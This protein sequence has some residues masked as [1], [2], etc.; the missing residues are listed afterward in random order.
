MSMSATWTLPDKRTQYQIPDENVPD[1]ILINKILGSMRPA[2]QAKARKE[3]PRRSASASSLLSLGSNPRPASAAGLAPRGRDVGV[4]CYPAPSPS[5]YARQALT[6]SWRTGQK[7]GR[8]RVALSMAYGLLA[9]DLN[10]KS[11]PYVVV[12][13]AG[14]RRKSRVI[15]KTLAPQW[16]ETLEFHGVLD[17]FLESGVQLQVYD[18]DE[19][20]SDDVLGELTLQLD[21]ELR[22]TMEPTSID[23]VER[24]SPEGYLVFTVTWLP[25]D[26]AQLAFGS[27]AAVAAAAAEAQPEPPPPPAPQPPPVPPPPAA[28]RTAAHP[29]TPSTAPTP[30]K[31]SG[32]LILEALTT[33]APRARTRRTV[34]P[35]AAG[36]KE[37]ERVMVPVLLPHKFDYVQLTYERF[38]QAA[39]LSQAAEERNARLQGRAAW[40]PGPMVHTAPRLVRPPSASVFERAAFRH[41]GNVM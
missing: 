3:Q 4:P 39:A 30:S 10:G 8:L 20:G 11:D 6:K 33:K 1:E 18:Y 35:T 15:K 13:A 5:R 22:C 34:R 7:L 25:E 16:E 17:D 23:Y 27:A 38:A 36:A 12:H 29:S 14:Q 28:A 21:H 31:S 19:V 9:A 40:K 37:R 26:H 41:P 2:Q 32:D 24:L